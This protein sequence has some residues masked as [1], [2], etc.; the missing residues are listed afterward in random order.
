LTSNAIKFTD[1]GTVRLSI[2]ENDDGSALIFTVRDTGIGMSQETLSRLFHRFEQADQSTTRKYGGTGLGLS[3]TKSLIDLMEG[4]IT[5]KSKLNKGSTFT[6]KIPAKKSDTDHSEVSDGQIAAPD[7]NRAK[8]LVAEDNK[9][10]QFVVKGIL[11]QVNADISFAE[12]GLEAVEAVQKSD[13]DLI[14]MDIQMPIMDGLEACKIIR[15]NH[16]NL[17]IIALTANAFDEDKQHYLANGFDGYLPKPIDQQ[18]LFRELLR[19]V[20]VCN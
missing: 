16:Q 14:L 17:P 4:N 12:S 2:E 3:I 7:L 11:Q 20:K 6:V 18:L 19:L 15:E 9:V 1:K 13:F 10:N 8:I 5:A